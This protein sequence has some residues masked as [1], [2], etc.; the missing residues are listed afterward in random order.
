[1]PSGT[2][3]APGPLLARILICLIAHKIKASRFMLAG[4][5]RA[6]FSCRRAPCACSCGRRPVQSL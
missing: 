6:P 2:R 5:P 4:L 1:M 3:R